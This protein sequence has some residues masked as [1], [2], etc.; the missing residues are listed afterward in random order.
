MIASE[1]V[2]FAK[3]GGLADVLGALPAALARLGHDVTVFIPRYRGIP[4]GQAVGELDVSLS[5]RTLLARFEQ[6]ETAPG[7]RAVLVDCPELYD[8]AALYGIGNDDYP[9]NAVRFA[10]F[11]KASLEFAARTFERVDVVHAHDWQTGLVPVYLK[12]QYANQPVLGAATSIFTVHNRAYQGLFPADTLPTLDL[13][14]DLFGVDALEYWGKISF[15]KAGI[16]FSRL[17]TTVSPTYAQEIQTP[18]CGFGFDGILRRRAP[19]LI[20]ILNGID[21]D[22]WNPLTD[23]ALP[24]PFGPDD[25]AGKAVAK[26]ALLSA[27]GMAVG[28]E[29]MKRPL[30]GMVSRLVPQKG[31]DLLAD[32]MSDLLRLD[33]C[34][35]LLGTGDPTFEE[36]WKAAAKT[37]PD[38]VNARIGFDE[39]LAHLIEGGA[40]MFLMPSRFEPCGLNQMYS[41]RYGTVPVVR[42]TGGLDDTVEEYRPRTGTGTG[43][44]FRAYTGRALIRAL[45]HALDVYQEPERWR[46][47]QLA[48]MKQDHSWTVSA[49]RYVKVYERA[50]GR[51]PAVRPPHGA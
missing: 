23:R 25:L 21:T 16:N 32:A 17:I 2:P 41:L 27:F 1:A 7:L 12:R 19:D 26:K 38:R 10:F 9:D 4:A 42:A 34:F 35:L 49:R 43:F 11:S 45:R 31:F 40:D 8:R 15:L 39:R 20:G 51:A 3:T 50:L 29:A 44:K 18:E 5:G 24:A 22:E 48:G 30:V 28:E 6:H 47:V 36:Q 33:A 13:G 14:W 37:H 46:A